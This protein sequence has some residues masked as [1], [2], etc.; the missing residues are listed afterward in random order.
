MSIILGLDP[1]TTTVG[2][3]V[4]ESTKNVRKILHL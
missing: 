3:A 1:G 4:I 2:F